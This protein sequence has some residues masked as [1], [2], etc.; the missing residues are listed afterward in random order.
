LAPNALAGII[1][2]K[3]KAA[4]VVAAEFLINFLLV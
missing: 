2:G 1:L 3:V 4:A